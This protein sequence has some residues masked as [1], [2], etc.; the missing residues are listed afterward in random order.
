MKMTMRELFRDWLNL[1]NTDA[2]TD[3]RETSK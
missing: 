2:M 3:V 1:G